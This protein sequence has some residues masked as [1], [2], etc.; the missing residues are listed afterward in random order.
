MNF[1]GFIGI[2][3]DIDDP[4]KSGKV[5]IKIINEHFDKIDNEDLIWAN[6]MMPTT[7]A[8]F[9]G[10]GWSPTGIMIN[11]YVFGCYLDG[12][13]KALPLVMGTF[14]IPKRAANGDKSDVSP[15][16]LGKKEGGPVD[17]KLP[18]VIGEPKS[19]YNAEYPHNKVY[20]SAG[21]HVIEIDD[22][23]GAERI[24]AYH[25][26]GSYIEMGPEGDI[27]TKAANKSVDISIN[28]KDIIVENGELTIETKTDGI[29]IRSKGTVTLTS[30]KKI[31]LE[32]PLISIN[33]E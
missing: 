32:A 10:N 26:S 19:K 20:K 23:P 6:I 2:V 33:G 17:K 11:S 30:D 3:V 29:T 1:V 12:Q 31:I 28:T 9:D 27:I 24:H 8:S 13:G 14:H 7:S 16:A 4:E 15:I 18:L 5:R 21:G 22:T 25:S